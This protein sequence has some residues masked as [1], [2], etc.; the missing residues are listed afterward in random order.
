MKV[1]VYSTHPWDECSLD[2][3]NTDHELLFLETK[4]DATTVSLSE[5]VDAVCVFVSDT[6]DRD[7][8]EQLCGHGVRYIALRSA[9]F[10]HVDL[11]ALPSVAS[12]SCGCPRTLHTL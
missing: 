8:V 2:G 5:G 9:G 11:K 12:P 7:V 4:L 3:A 10:N 1:A 6:V